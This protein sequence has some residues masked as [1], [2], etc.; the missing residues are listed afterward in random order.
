MKIL[1]TGGAGFIGSHLAGFHLNKN[2]E[3]YVID[4]LLTG[5]EKNIQTYIN[6]KNFHFYKNDVLDFKFSILP[7]T[8]LRAS[9]FAFDMIYHLASPA[10]PIQYKKYP[11]ETLLVN[12]EGT[13]KLLDF[14]IKSKSKKFVLASTSEVYGDPLV[15]PQPETYWGNVNPVGC[16]SCYDE[17]KRYAEA[18]T[19]AYYNKYGLDLRIA[20]I[21]NTYGPNMEIHDG[22]VV[23]NFIVQAL[24]NQPITVYGNGEQSR[25][26]CFVSDMIDALYSLGTT[27]NLNGSIINLGNPEEFSILRLAE[28]IK[29]QTNS[30]SE[31]VMESIE[32]DDPKLRKPDISKA[33]RLLNWQPKVK[34]K[35]GLEKTI[36]YFKKVI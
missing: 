5:S 31:I 4:N 2:D 12:S 32:E 27:S 15:N 8:S 20:R 9:N 22:R 17:S 7:S 25:S 29:K 28:I 35:E 23:S 1:I 6:N 26:F 11:I 30:S 16:R 24:K 34:F 10:S 3:V 36:E 14:M 19:M 18:L 33:N 21:F 13:R